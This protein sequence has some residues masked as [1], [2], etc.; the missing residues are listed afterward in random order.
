M[1]R[2]WTWYTSIGGSTR[3]IPLSPGAKAFGASPVMRWTT[4]HCWVLL[5]ALKFPLGKYV[6]RHPRGCGMGAR[7]AFSFDFPMIVHLVIEVKC[8]GIIQW[9]TMDS[10]TNSMDSQKLSRLSKP[11]RVASGICQCMKRKG[12]CKP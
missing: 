3:P 11:F 7:D 4:Y 9:N 1:G 12:F 2:C 6:D 8:E 10:I 5:C